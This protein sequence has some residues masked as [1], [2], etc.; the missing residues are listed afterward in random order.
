MMKHH[1]PW[2]FRHHGHGHFT[3]TTPCGYTYNDDPPALHTTAPR[4]ESAPF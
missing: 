4:P 2:T 1:A 3:I